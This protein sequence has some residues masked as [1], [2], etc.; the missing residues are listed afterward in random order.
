MSAKYRYG[1]EYRV[2][3]EAE[4]LPDPTVAQIVDGYKEWV[5][6]EEFSVIKNRDT[7]E[8]LPCAV[9]KLGNVKYA[10]NKRAQLY[11]VIDAFDSMVLDRPIP[12]GR[13]KRHRMGYALLITLTYDHKLYS[14]VDAYRRC[15]EDINRFKAQF[16]KLIDSPY[17]SM[18]VKEGSKS[19]YP[20]PHLIFIVCR[21]LPVFLHKDKWRVQ[22][23]GLY[24]AIHE[25]WFNASGG[26]YNCDIEAIVGNS[27]K[28][29]GKATRSAMSYVLKYITKASD[30]DAGDSESQ[31]LADVTH[32]MMKFTGCR[33]IIG[34]KFLAMLGLV[35]DSGLPLD[36]IQKKNELKRLQARK[37]EL[38]K[39]EERYKGA[40][41]W[42]ASPQYGELCKID[43]MI[44]K[45]K[46]EIR[47]LSPPSPWVYV[48]TRTFRGTQRAQIQTW[49]ESFSEANATIRAGNR[50][51]ARFDDAS[52]IEAMLDGSDS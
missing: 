11:P 46:A 19:G 7:G 6:V 10:I 52:F 25:A 41:G 1:K 39:L 43:R 37:E 22:D 5:G 24:K 28:G 26:S 21:P 48:S 34:K 40:F 30:A 29:T 3:A 33:D 18:A 17:V 45:V 44:S 15:G 27:V 16:T 14:A 38:T 42:L 13:D 51:V 47:E 23:K 35:D 20:A 8:Y 31:Y 9:S 32:A 12:G 49:L 50:Q 2:C 4:N 36:L